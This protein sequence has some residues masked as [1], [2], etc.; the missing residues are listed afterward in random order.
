MRIQHLRVLYPLEVK[1]VVWG[2]FHNQGMAWLA[3]TPHVTYVYFDS[4]PQLEGFTNTH[5]HTAKAS[6]ICHL[7]FLQVTQKF[8]NF[9]ITM[10]YESPTLSKK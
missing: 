8:I 2:A 4:P 5:T 3:R 10:T 7:Q 6:S 9:M 1:Y